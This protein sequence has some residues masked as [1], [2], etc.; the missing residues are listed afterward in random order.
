MQTLTIALEKILFLPPTRVTDDTSVLTLKNL[1]L[2]PLCRW[3]HGDA[4]P[5]LFHQWEHSPDGRVW[6]FDLRP[7]ATFH[8]GMSCTVD[9]V[10]GF[11]DA[12]LTSVDMF[13]MPWAYARYFAGARFEALSATRLQV[14]SIE[15]FAD[16]V[17]VFSEFYLCRA[18]ADG[19][20]V[21]G[22][23]PYRVSAWTP[24]QE[25]VLERVAPEGDTT[26]QRI[27]V[28]AMADAQD[29]FDALR[30]GMVDVA[31]H[32]ERLDG[33]RPS[34]PGIDWIDQ[35]NTLSV[36]SYL[37][38]AQGL[39]AHP[40]ARLAIN[41]AVDVRHIIDELFDGRGEPSSTVVSCFHLGAREAALRPIACDP[42]LANALFEHAGVAGELV[43]RTPEYMPDKAGEITAMVAD[44]L[45]RVGVRTR[46]DTQTD[47]PAYA[48]QIGAKDMG[49]VAIFD[50]SPHSTYRILNDKISS[51]TRGI[52]WQGH[53]DATLEPLIVAARHALAPTERR[54][55]YGRCLA[56]LN[57]NPSWLY[58]FNPVESIGL[59][60]G[61]RA[62]L[63]RLSLNHKGLLVLQ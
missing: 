16:I 21:L 13:G 58:L 29:R 47:R 40:A 3:E 14:T 55:A 61:L 32:L 37:N 52:W 50:S 39:F 6:R 27:R 57:A 20:P 44:A 41:H 18:N 24:E 54:A 15:P 7:G 30:Q 10:I 36:M 28:L 12:I 2:E 45:Q 19:A 51:V 48:R 34:V 43:L 63:P 49:D 62:Q 1:V 23:G 53:D 5:G 9:D 56:R 42:A 17:D 4:L 33:P 38:V 35:A 8:D 46:I 25:A 11:L 60:A 31:H 22:T 26:P 59:R